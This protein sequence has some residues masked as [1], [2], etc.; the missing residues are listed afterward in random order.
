MYGNGDFVDARGAFLFSQASFGP[1]IVRRQLAAGTMPFV[2]PA[3]VFRRDV[4]G[5]LDGFDERFKD[6]ADYDFFARAAAAGFRFGKT[7]GR[8]VAAFRVHHRQMSTVQQALVED[9]QVTRRRECGWLRQYLRMGL[10]AAWKVRNA[11]NYLASV[12]HATERT[13]TRAKP[14]R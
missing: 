2:Q 10:S 8:P 4:F 3:A 6:I 7:P 12:A 5:R 1:L 13:P 9:E 11:F 14:R